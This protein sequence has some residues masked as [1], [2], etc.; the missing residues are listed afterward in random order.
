MFFILFTYYPV[1]KQSQ[2]EY[3]QRNGIPEAFK[4][5]LK[6]QQIH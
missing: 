3:S 5:Q 4:A 1:Q 2:T 6:V